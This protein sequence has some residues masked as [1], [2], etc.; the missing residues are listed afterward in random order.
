MQKIVEFKRRGFLV[1]ALM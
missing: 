1:T